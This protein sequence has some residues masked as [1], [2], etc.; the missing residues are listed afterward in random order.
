M[1]PRSAPAESTTG[2][3]VAPPQ[4]RWRLVLARSAGAPR[5]A[6]RELAEAWDEALE[7]SGL[8]LHRPAGRLRARIALGAPLPLGM[9]GERELAEILLVERVPIWRMRVALDGRLPEGWSLVDLFDVWVGGPPLAGRVIAADYRVEL[10][11]AVEPVEIAGAARD[12]LQARELPR[13]RQKGEGTV[14][15]DLRPLLAEVSVDGSG[16]RSTLRIRTRIHPELGS[17]R[18]EEVVAALGDRLGHPLEVT[19]IVRERLILADD[20]R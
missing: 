2:S 6:G 18:P 4:Q 5:L 7:G 15:Y 14:A 1:E 19:T 9:A 3:P 16:K 20:A 8:P 10:S 11:E 13:V 12:L 17:G